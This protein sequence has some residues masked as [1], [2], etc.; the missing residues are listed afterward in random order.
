[1]HD[2]IPRHA[3]SCRGA[4]RR[5]PAYV[6]GDRDHLVRRAPRHGASHRR[7]LLARAGSSRASGLSY[8][9][10]TASTGWSPRSPCPYAGGTLVPVNSRYTGHEVA[11]LVDRT[12][13]VLVVVADGFLGR[14]Q[15]AELRAASDLSSVRE[16]MTSQI[17]HRIAADPG[18]IDSVADA[19]TPDDVAD[20]LFT[21]G[22]TGRPKGAMSAHRQT[23]GVARA[24]AEL[25]GVQRRRPLPR[26]QPVLPLVR[27]QDRDRG[28]PADRRHPLPGR[29]VRP[30]RDDG[31]DP[32]RADHPPPW[33][34]DDLPV[35]AQRPEPR[36]VRPLLAPA[37]RHRRRRRTGRPDR[38]DA[39]G[40]R[41][42][43][44]GHGVRDDRGRG[45]HDVPRGRHRRDG[46]H[47]LRPRHPRDG[48][49]DRASI[50]R[51]VCSAATT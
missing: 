15:I 5:P 26:G 23:I 38:A 9:R 17:S 43:P 35:A 36:R 22:T 47:H 19:V 39:R 10:P 1:M 42:R 41:H 45:R 33:R 21:S 8:G 24:W 4:V 50:G 20:I 6:E 37:R 11:E 46:G 44:R 2:T 18:D 40:P 48:D 51:A 32:V 7:G 16:V 14:A 49:P 27:L 29:D 34:A 31:A 28:R 3:P 13:A 30:R 25:G 12:G